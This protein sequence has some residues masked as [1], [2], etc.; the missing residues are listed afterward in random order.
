MSTS[1]QPASVPAQMGLGRSVLLHI[2]PGALISLFYLLVG[3]SIIRVGY[4]RV[5]AL[6]LGI[7]LVLIPVELGFLL[8]LGR[9][10]N[11]RTSLEGIVLYR[12][13]LPWRT[14]ALLVP[15]L[16]IWN[17]LCFGLLSSVEGFLASRIFSW[18]PLWSLPASGTAQYAGVQQSALVTTFVAGIALNGI[19]GPVVEELYFRGYLLPRISRLGNLGAA[20]FNVFLF[21]LYHFFSPWGNLPRIL[22]LL[23]LVY[24]VARKRN[25]Y[26]SIW[27]H[28]CLNTI[29]ML[30]TLA[31]IAGG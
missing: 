28:C 26:L 17:A 20:A 5:A 4:P 10:R 22:A 8:Y 18:M 25:I 30:L 31:S 15:A 13:P 6:L 14:Y 19:A 7:L 21:S 16:L 24:V 27:T 2:L 29:G 1:S 3:P 11:H 9:K 12:E 23:P